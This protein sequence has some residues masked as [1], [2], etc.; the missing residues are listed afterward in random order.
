M[1]Q[2]SNKYQHF[3]INKNNNIVDI[4]NALDNNKYFCPYCHN[5]MI[6]KRGQI[7]QWH[8]AH[9]TDKCSYDNYLHSIAKRLIAD[10]FN[11]SE[12]TIL[13]MNCINQCNQY[14]KCSIYNE[15]ICSITI[16]KSFDLKKYYSKCFLEYKYNNFIADIYCEHKSNPIFIEIYVTH[17][18][19][20]EKIKSGI[21]I[22][23]IQIQSEEDISHIISST[24]L[25]ENQNIKL[26]N[27]NRPEEFTYHTEQPIQKYIL[28]HSLKSYIDKSYTC[29]NYYNIRKGIY[30]ISIPYD[31]CIPLFINCGS[32]YTI[33]QAMAYHDG[34]LVKSCHICKWQTTN[35]MFDEPAICKLYKKCGNPKYCKDN[36][37]ITCSMFKEDKNNINQAISEFKE[38]AKYNWT[39]IWIKHK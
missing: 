29:K 18:C 23:E 8:F 32:L 33:G 26:Y 39:D 10:W 16:Q 34:Y 4:K 5:E 15:N 25:I 21:R 13:T 22:I 9:K 17:K 12:H 14:K 31:D 1:I 7:R 2:H 24:E 19:S 30:E 38:Y 37:P 3:A 36:N 6:L 35:D 27:F 11:K 20:P 28:F